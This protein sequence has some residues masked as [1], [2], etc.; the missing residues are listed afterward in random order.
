MDLTADLNDPAS[1]VSDYTI[2]SSAAIDKEGETFSMTF[3]GF[4]AIPGFTSI[5]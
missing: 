5:V 3:T 1:L 2:T 4:D